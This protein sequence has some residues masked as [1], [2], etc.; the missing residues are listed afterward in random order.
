MPSTSLI[1]LLYI[2]STE[3]QKSFMYVI[4]GVLGLPRSPQTAGGCGRASS[5]PQLRKQLGRWIQ[6]AQE[7]LGTCECWLGLKRNPAES[8]LGNHGG[9]NASFC[10]P[11]LV[12]GGCNSWKSGIIGKGRER[13]REGSPGG[14]PAQGLTPPIALNVLLKK[15]NVCVLEGSKTWEK[16]GQSWVGGRW[17]GGANEMMYLE[18]FPGLNHS[19]CI[20]ISHSIISCDYK[21]NL[22]TLI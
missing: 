8:R 2:P 18:L 7:A 20:T 21:V 17:R 19:H 16:Q 11:L 12:E 22:M 14:I 6:K 10:F 4:L 9:F 15:C 5:F 1:Y 13:Q 3:F